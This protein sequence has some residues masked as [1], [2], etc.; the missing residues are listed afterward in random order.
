MMEETTLARKIEEGPH[1][2]KRRRVD[3]VPDLDA[4][5]PPWRYNPSAWSQRIPR[6]L[7]AAYMGLCQMIFS[8]ECSS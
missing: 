8:S 5:A 3:S 4:P 1:K 2:T 7:I 6:F